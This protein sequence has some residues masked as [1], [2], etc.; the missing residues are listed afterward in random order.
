MV[1]VQKTEKGNKK[2]K[3]A[4]QAVLVEQEMESGFHKRK[5]ILSTFTKRNIPT[6]ADVPP[7]LLFMTL[8]CQFLS[9]LGQ[10]LYKNALLS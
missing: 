2:K 1:M 5:W 3:K 9:A 6:F 7:G 8:I 4:T 10:R